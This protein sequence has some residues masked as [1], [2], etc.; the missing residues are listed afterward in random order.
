MIL[1]VTGTDGSGK[2]TVVDYLVREKGFTHYPARA[3]FIEEI[4]R[5]GIEN[6][7]ANM[8]LMGNYFRATHGDDFLIQYYLPKIAEAGDAKAAI[9]SIRAVAEAE[10]LKKNGGILVAVDANEHLRYKRV[11]QRRSSSDQ[12]SFEEFKQQEALEL[13][14]PDPH[15][16]QKRKVME[17]ADYTVTNDGTLE[18]LHAQVDAVLEKI[19]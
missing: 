13:D 19:S 15:G 18:E 5:R 6:N 8:R 16:M 3:I 14:D 1:G 10:T 4:E 11:Q 12:V 2:G 7:R 9:E 17:M